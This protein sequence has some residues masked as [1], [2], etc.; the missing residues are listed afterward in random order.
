MSNKIK[1]LAQEL[2]NSIDSIEANPKRIGVVTI[3]P[4]KIYN[5][6][7]GNTHGVSVLPG[8]K[9]VYGCAA[10]RFGTMLTGF[11]VEEFEELKV[12]KDISYS[13]FF[14]DFKII[15]TDMPVVLDLSRESDYIRYKFALMRPEIANTPDDVTS[16]TKYVMFDEEAEAAKLTVKSDLKM[17]AYILLSNMS[18]EDQLDFLKLFG[19]VTK[20]L[21]P[22]V[23][24]AK[25]ALIIETDGKTFLSRYNDKHR[26]ERILVE[27][28]VQAR[29]LEKRGTSF[30][31]NED[32]L[33][34]TED[35]TIQYLKS[36]KNNELRI[37][38][39]TLL[40]STQG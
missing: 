30:Y 9:H 25:L 19:I 32:L 39:I 20:G 11:T 14:R 31:Y 22:T 3:K 12:S 8:A 2:S 17:D 26:G 23:V 36:P 21:S 7:E 33:G 38:L 15:L 13:I 40:K 10:D 18:F 24:K 1:G 16:A 6:Q 28:L 34:A 27:S 37:N 4:V 5:R 35:I 29:I